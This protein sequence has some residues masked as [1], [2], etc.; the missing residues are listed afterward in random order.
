MALA[1]HFRLL[2]A[3]SVAF[4]AL[5]Q[6][7]PAGT[8]LAIRLKTKVSTQ[9]S[10]SGD[11]VEAVVIANPLAGATVR[12]VVETV[13]AST[14][15]DERSQ[16]LLKFTE[17]QID[18]VKLPVSARV[19]GVDNAREKVAD[20]G[21]IQ[22]ILASETIT[23]HLDEGLDQLG[24]KYPTLGG[25]L[26][27]VKNAVLK[28]ASTDITYPPG[29]EM[30]LRLA[31]PLPGARVTGAPRAKPIAPRAMLAALVAREPFQT[32]AQRPPKPSDIVNVLLIGSEDA[33]R[34]AFADAGWALAASLT[35]RAK[36]ETLLALAED[37]GYNEAPVSVLTLEG[38]PPDLVFEKTTDTFAR[39]HHLRL[40]RR[41][42]AFLGRPVWAVAA[43]HDINIRFSDA[44]RT[45]IHR[46]DPEID[47]ER[48]KVAAD[49]LFTGRV[50]GMELLDRPRVPR[51]AQN[52]TGDSL[53]TDGKIAALLL[54]E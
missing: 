46:V 31:A 17:I 44:E 49:L 32:V 53:E 34:H 30:T 50:R 14:Q 48:D 36:F 19:S 43:T 47:R 45:F 1:A 11:P 40:W 15:P 51:H 41:P 27:A 5:A 10:R 39:R 9:T 28:P 7:V 38:Q 35:P 20:D 18:A 3:F 4:P 24:E 33:V 13:T 29:V 6:P 22:G 8:E 2:A 42:A 26:G 54:S 52:A 37:R 23:G 16:L 25:V 21:A 12:G